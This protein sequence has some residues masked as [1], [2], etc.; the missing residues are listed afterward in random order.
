VTSELVPYS[1]LGTLLHT[2]G[3]ED[4][5]DW[6]ENK[7]FNATLCVDW[8]EPGARAKRIIILREVDGEERTFPILVDDLIQLL[9]NSVVRYG[10]ITGRWRVKRT[11]RNPIFTIV[12]VDN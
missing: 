7:A 8:V 6:R 4:V 11:G 5:P 12:K 3:D 10:V 2:V 9:K 1:P